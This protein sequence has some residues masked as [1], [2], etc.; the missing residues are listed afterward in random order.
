LAFLRAPTDPHGTALYE[1][2]AMGWMTEGCLRSAITAA[3]IEVVQTIWMG[4][5][6]AGRMYL[7]IRSF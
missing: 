1:R 7:H 5:L 4:Y 6:K 2:N 3:T